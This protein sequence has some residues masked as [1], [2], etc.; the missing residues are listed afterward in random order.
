MLAER[1]SGALCAGHSFSIEETNL[2]NISLHKT[3]MLPIR[4]KSVY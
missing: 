3:Y 1:M 2:V 4:K